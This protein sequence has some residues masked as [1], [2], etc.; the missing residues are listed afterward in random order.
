CYRGGK[1]DG[2]DARI[3]KALRFVEQDAALKS[4]LNEQMA[5]DNRIAGVIESISPSAAFLDKARELEKLD[6]TTF[7]WRAVL[8]TPPIIGVG[9]ALL[10]L[11]GWGIYFALN[12]MQNFPGKDSAMR[13]VEI[14]DEMSGM[15]LEPEVA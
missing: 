5:L 11:I 14:T 6:T 1:Y 10:V 8:K 9:I 2:G 4:K 7:N 13:M 12:R 15:A 3:Q